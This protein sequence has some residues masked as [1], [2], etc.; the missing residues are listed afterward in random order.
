MRVSPG[1]MILLCIILLLCINIFG[2]YQRL[3]YLRRTPQPALPRRGEVFVLS[4]AGDI[5]AHDVNYLN[6]AYEEIYR[7]VGSLLK[8]DLLSFGNLE[9]PVDAS[10]PL[11]NYPRFNV[12]PSYVD[13]EVEAGFQIFSAAN[14]HSSDQGPESILAT[15]DYLDSLRSRTGAQWSGL[16]RHADD[17]MLPELIEAEGMRIGFL[18]IT[19]FLNL[20]E[21]SS[22]VNRVNYH[23]P[24]RRES[25]LEYIREIRKL[26]DLFIL[27]VHGGVE[28]ARLP[29]KDKHAFFHE[30]IE[31]GVDIVWG[32]HPHVLQPWEMTARKDGRRALIINSA[33]NFISGQTWHMRPEEVHTEIPFRGEGAVYRVNLVR[34]PEKGASIRGVTAVP[35][36]SYRD[37]G[38]GMVLASYTE[39]IT[40]EKMDPRWRQFYRL[41]EKPLQEVLKPFE[42]RNLAR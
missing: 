23:N 1:T 26:Y 13:A 4:F 38:R 12:H 11:Q 7:G 16:R 2:L 9:F 30:L 36:I 25:F 21:G 3:D 41:R 20:D 39:L 31:A 18:A 40:D 17:P 15:A 8:H 27:S 28:Y 32:H 29:D 10:K 14:N 5:M 34:S 35:V 42:W 22:L 37:P 6:P 19:A 24:E 33:G